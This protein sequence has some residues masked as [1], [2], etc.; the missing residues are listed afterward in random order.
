M[1]TEFAF[2][3]PRPIPEELDL[4]DLDDDDTL[5]KEEYDFMVKVNLYH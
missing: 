1:A 3:A 2:A 5:G 4:C